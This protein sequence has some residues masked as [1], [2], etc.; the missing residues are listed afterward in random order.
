MKL[1]RDMNERERRL[2]DLKH[3]EWL[4]EIKFAAEMRMAYH[5]RYIIEPKIRKSN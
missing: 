4:E 2:A 5:D 1:Y 3:E